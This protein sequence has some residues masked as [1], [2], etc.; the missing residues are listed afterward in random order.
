MTVVS[1]KL[2]LVLVVAHCTG[3][4]VV[5]GG[6]VSGGCNSYHFLTTQ[7][8]NLEKPKKHP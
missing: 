3:G 6:V 8:L 2:L 5:S 1:L 7:I 4:G